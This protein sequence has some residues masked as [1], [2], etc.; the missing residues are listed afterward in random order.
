[1]LFGAFTFVATAQTPQRQ[2]RFHTIGN[3]SIN[4]PF[5]SE[6]Y[7]I[8]DSCAQ[9]TRYCHF[10]FADKKFFGKFKDVSTADP[11]LILAE[12]SYTD[13]GLKNGLFTTHYL[14]GN[15]QASG[16][17]KND[18]YDGKWQLFYESGK[19]EL[20]FEV[21]NGD[22]SI[23]DAWK[24]DGAK[25]IDNGNGIYT[26]D[27]G[28]FYWKGKLVN[29]KPEGTW[30]LIRTDDITNT[31]ISK[32]YFKK[33]KFHDGER[34]IYDYTDSSHIALVNPS[35]LP[36]VTAEKMYISETPCNGVRRRHIVNA[37]YRDGLSSFS[38]YISDAVSPYF[39]KIDLK[40][41]E[42]T[43][44]IDGEISEKGDLINLKSDG[45]L[46]DDIARGL[47]LKLKNLPSLHPATA[48]GKPV[49][50]KFTISFKIFGGA[51][52]FRYRFLPIEN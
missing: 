25:I 22:C 32:E 44:D 42:N 43:I 17:F 9:I 47:I 13:D 15:L 46:N 45:T 23:I 29:G 41:I 7:L 50:Q 31:P 34:G 49:K 5:N 36:F 52:Q 1:L 3:D 30:K 24:P 4:L 18:K 40:G 10:K 28:S 33:G 27:L 12:G 35:K 20:T 14:N 6:Y 19:P 48:D 2:I 16:N 51:Y 11:K 38:Q 39:G 21:T 37:Q 26:D 8:E